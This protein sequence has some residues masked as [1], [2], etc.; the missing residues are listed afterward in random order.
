MFEERRNGL[1]NLRI[2]AAKKHRPEAQGLTIASAYS[3][4]F[5]G[6]AAFNRRELEAALERERNRQRYG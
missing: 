5:T 3:R 2:R 1:G 6:T 4:D